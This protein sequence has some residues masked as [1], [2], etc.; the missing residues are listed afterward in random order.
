MQKSQQSD[1][2]GHLTFIDISAPTFD[3][4]A[5]GLGGADTRRYL[6]VIDAAGRVYVGIDGV[7]EF[8]SAIGVGK[9]E[10][11][12]WRIGRRPGF[13]GLYAAAYALLA[14]HRHHLS[15]MCRL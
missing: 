1:R 14:S 13:H 12:L 7:M 2:A 10:A 9:V 4:H 5:Y 8:R 11:W 6:H 15:R 3:P